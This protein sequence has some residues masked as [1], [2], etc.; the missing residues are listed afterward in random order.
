MFRWRVGKWTSTFGGHFGGF[1][2]VFTDVR[3]QDLSIDKR[4][5]RGIEAAVG[6]GARLTPVQHQ[7]F[8]QL[9]RAGEEPC[10]K[11][12]DLLLQAHTGTGKTIAFLLPALQRLLA[13]EARKKGLRRAEGVSVLV[14]APT[15]ELVLQ[16][17]K[18]ASRLLQYSGG[19]VRSSFVVGGFSVQ[20]DIERLKAD[21]PHILFATPWR[22]V[23]H[24]QS[25]PHF[26]RALGSVQSLV[27][28]EADRLLNPVFVH[29]VDYIFRRLPCSRPQMILCSATFNEHIQKFA[30]RSLRANLEV[31]ST[32]A[33]DVHA[34]THP[35]QTKTKVEVAKPVDQVLIRY[36]PHKFL[37]VLHALLVKE[38]LAAEGEAKRVLVIF[39]TVR[40]L[41]FFYV[42]LKHRANMPGLLSLHRSLSADRRRNRAVQ[43]SKGAPATS[44]ALFATDVAARGMDFD[45]HSVIQVGCPEDREQY[46]HRAGRTG[47]LESTG[48]SF[49]LLNPLE[50]ITLKELDGLHLHREEHIEEDTT[51]AEAATNIHGWW[52]DASI[53]AS[54]HLFYASA[55]SFYL[56][57]IGRLRA[58]AGEIVRTV[59]ALIQSAGLPKD[60]GLPA[61]PKGL[62]AKLRQKDELV[63]VRTETV[64]E[65]WDV[66]AALSPHPKPRPGKNQASELG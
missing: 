20:E 44:G 23:H 4:L 25:T 36:D 47:R 26:V 39:P 5:L 56:H 27:L 40:W 28:D 19:L 32:T 41:Q 13:E 58:N 30:V 3:F 60:Y 2:R 8:S 51:F 64:R 1:R 57:D 24:L 49:L 31:I 35:V 63:A 37:P 43:F 54:A 11:R 16:L 34:E 14:L 53:S 66:L 62:A 48:R 61:L 17:A 21:A 45:V 42:L 18:V 9:Q 52:E 38:M 46:V 59:S 22:L 55:I 6:A 65:R 15:R 29:K 33:E 10:E 7:A 50:E 12:P